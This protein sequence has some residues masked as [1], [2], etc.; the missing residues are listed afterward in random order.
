MALNSLSSDARELEARL[1]I[2]INSTGDDAPRQCAALCLDYAEAARQ[3][4]RRRQQRSGRNGLRPLSTVLSPPPAASSAQVPTWTRGFYA[5][6]D[7]EPIDA[8]T[9][10][11]HDAHQRILKGAFMIKDEV[12]SILTANACSNVP[13]PPI[14]PRPL[15]DKSA[16]CSVRNVLTT[17]RAVY[18]ATQ[19]GKQAKERCNASKEEEPYRY[20]VAP[21]PLQAAGSV[22][23]LPGP[24]PLSTVPS[25]A[26]YQPVYAS[27]V[28]GPYTAVSFSAGSDKSPRYEP[29][30]AAIYGGI[31]AYEDPTMHRKAIND[32]ALTHLAAITE[33]LR[34]HN[35]IGRGAAGVGETE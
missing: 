33:D 30:H 21:P 28:S 14:T 34:R 32:D 2:I 23:G 5:G 9:L 13:K 29:V 1:K 31:Y 27:P 15:V 7:S 35:I 22:A 18:D 12:R 20:A 24:P 3:D 26:G 17:A 4:E 25:P 16:K 11:G 8:T 6:K 10:K 19:E